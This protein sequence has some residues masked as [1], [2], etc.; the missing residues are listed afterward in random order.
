MIDGRTFFIQAACDG[1]E[2]DPLTTVD[3]WADEKRVL[4]SVASREAGNYR[5][6][7]TP[8]LREIMQAL[9]VSES[10]ITD[11]AVMKAT[12]IGGS[13]VANNFIGYII[14][15]APGPILYMLPTV[16]LAERH[17]RNRIAPMIESI[18]SIAAKVHPSKSRT[19]GNT[20]LAKNFVGGA[21]YLAGSNSGSA[22]RNVSIRY[23]ILDDI[24]G[25][26]PDIGGEGS[27]V[28]LAERRTDT[29]SS[30]KKILKI[31]TPTI[32]GGSLIEKEFQ[33]SDQRYYHVPCPFCETRQILIFS[34]NNEEH[35]LHYT[36]ENGEV[37][38]VWYTCMNCR[39]KINEHY[40]NKMLKKGKWIPLQPN[41]SKRGYHISGLLSPLGFVSWRQIAQE[42]NDAKK[43]PMS[44]K[45]WVNTRLGEPYEVAG[46][47]PEWE[48]L[49]LRCEPYEPMKPPPGVIFITFGVDVQENRIVVV[50]R[51]WGVGEESWLIW[52]GE[53]YGDWESQLDDLIAYN[54]MCD[55]A[56]IS[57][58]GV[59][60]DSGYKTQ[61]V[62]SYC[63]KKDSRVFAVKGERARNKPVLGKPSE[64]DLNWRGKQIPRGVKLWPVGTDTAKSTLYGRLKNNKVPGP[65]CY[66]W[67]ECV[68]DEYFMQLTAEKMETHIKGG[69]PYLEWVK[70]RDRNDA[71]DAEIYAYAAAIRAGLLWL[72]RSK[73]TTPGLPTMPRK[74]ISVICS[75]LERQKE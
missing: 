16:E 3:E 37:T 11:I 14:D 73:S 15:C 53:I 40:K 58:A 45:V 8:Y 6:R 7:R 36:E 23:L 54:F 63:R 51:G 71:L 1:L 57:V 4:N 31:S 29:Y 19:G 70:T 41:R 25:F 18:P 61:Q 62:Y 75:Y 52:Y 28:S 34:T 48:N 17:S 27:P 59:A 24:D 56:V 30:R 39:E 2:L 13:E 66:H 35:G 32:K 67:Y 60:I 42:Y 26:E 20:V 9:S 72:G 50:I 38:D 21:L 69:F 43:D 64:Q 74:K 68:T 33:K 47:Q 55:D 46:E 10:E 65:C 44:M 22:F 5:T 49:R 12:Q